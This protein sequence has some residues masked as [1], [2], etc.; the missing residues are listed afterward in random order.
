MVVNPGDIV[1]SGQLLLAIPIAALA[2]LV[3]FAS[4]CVLPLVPG[5]LAYVGGAATAQKGAKA[6]TRDRAR[7][8]LGVVL[9][10][11][12]F[13]AIF[14]A[15]GFAFGGLGRWLVAY[16]PL[17]TQI[18]GA[19]VIIMGLVFIGQV[20]FLQRTFRPTWT[21]RTG[22]LGAPL[23]GIVFGI[24]WAP[25]V[26]P[27]LVAIQSLSF[28]SASPWR[29]ALLSFVYCLGLGIPFIIMAVGATWAT[30][31]VTFLRRHIRAINIV[32][33][34]LLI[35]IGLLMVTGIWTSL[36]SLLAGVMPNFV[37]AI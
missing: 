3:S 25:C 13:S 26:G 34:I 22:L 19:L 29:G 24:G 5:Y 12:G 37:P 7:L 33:G 35:V 30:K 27:T 15:Y 20:T 1:I 2:G 18:L 4:P 28:G 17:I 8:L 21:P 9:F 31:S 32:G 16:G 36:I 10:I 23:L 6:A 11:A 14:T